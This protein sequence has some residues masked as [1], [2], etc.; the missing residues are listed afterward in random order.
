M[1]CSQEKVLVVGGSHQVNQV[2]DDIN[3]G[4]L[5][6]VLMQNTP[7]WGHW[8]RTP[9]LSIALL[10][11]WENKIEK[12]AQITMNEN[13]TSIAGVPTWTIVLINRILDTFR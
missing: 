10:D 4:D 6:A 13:V 9:E 8:I 2:N 5:S 7:F 3:Y 1:I 11:E 12:L